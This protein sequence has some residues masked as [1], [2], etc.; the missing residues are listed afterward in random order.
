MSSASASGTSMRTKGSST[1]GQHTVRCSGNPAL[2][3][4][5]A[6]WLIASVTGACGAAPGGSFVGI[7]AV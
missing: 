2:I 6:A 4:I 5:N 1:P 3:L 7:C